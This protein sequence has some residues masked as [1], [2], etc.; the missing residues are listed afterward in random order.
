MSTVAYQCPCCG[1]PLS[2][3]AES[4]KLE[5]GA[6]GNSYE[7]DVLEIMNQT[8]EDEGVRFDLPEESFAAEDAAHM[9]AYICKGCGA[10]LMTEETT[11]ATE[12]ETTVTTATTG[13][14]TAVDVPTT[15][16]TVLTAAP[17]ETATTRETELTSSAGD[18]P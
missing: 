14:T 17:A 2:Y 13:S 3:G 4:G 9:H 1:A 15:A 10:E 11:T 12:V 18:T 16:T 5:C 8:T 7:L 6:C